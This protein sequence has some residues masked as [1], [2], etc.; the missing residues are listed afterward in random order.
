MSATEA[1]NEFLHALTI[2]HNKR[3]ALD[4]DY[5]KFL[6]VPASSPKEIDYYLC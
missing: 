3:F 2:D 1:A 5:E 4:N 6:F